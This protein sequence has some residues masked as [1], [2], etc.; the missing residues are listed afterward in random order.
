MITLEVPDLQM[1]SVMLKPEVRRTKGARTVPSDDLD[2]VIAL[3][4]PMSVPI[5]PDKVAADPELSAF[6]AAQKDR[7]AYHHVH[8]ACT[9]R[10][11]EDEP[12][13]QAVLKVRLART[14]SIP[15]PQPIAWS[16]IPRSIEDVVEVSKTVKFGGD[17]KLIGVVAG[18]VASRERTEK[19]KLT[20]LF[21]TA[22][23]EQRPDPFWEFV[24]TST[25]KI[26]GSYRFGLLV[27]TPIGTP[28]KGIV[29]L[30]AKVQRKHF[31]IIPY[32]TDFEGAPEISFSLP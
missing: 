6:L 5:G 12:F 22:Y 18:T 29:K 26:H 4:S 32:R 13:V 14:D 2:A 23:N 8:L 28:V 16:M 30:S 3:G 25:A 17:L 31:G 7:Y 19:S 21:L 10:P 1:Q 9:L 27:Q 24:N 11:A 20:E 15:E